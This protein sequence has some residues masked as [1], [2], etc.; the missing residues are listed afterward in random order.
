LLNGG[1]PPCEQLEDERYE[2]KHQQK[3]N[4]STQRVAAHNANQPEHQQDYKQGPK[5]L[6]P[7]SKVKKNYKVAEL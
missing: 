3:V 6:G 4:K 7:T 5:H 1:S 2:S